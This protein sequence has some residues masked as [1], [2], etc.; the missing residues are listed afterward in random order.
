[1][2]R[3]SQIRNRRNMPCCSPPMPQIDLTDD[4]HARAVGAMRADPPIES[5]A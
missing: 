3:G 4:E 5:T 1:L 2:L